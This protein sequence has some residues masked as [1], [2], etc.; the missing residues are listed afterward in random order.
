[1]DDVGRPVNAISDL[2][3]CIAATCMER[4]IS[5]FHQVSDRNQSNIEHGSLVPISENKRSVH[6]MACILGIKQLQGR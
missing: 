5:P 1:V 6:F 4:T 2:E 3:R